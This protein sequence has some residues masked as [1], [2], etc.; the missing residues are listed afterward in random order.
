MSL[1]R[2]HTSNNVN[3]YSFLHTTYDIILWYKNSI[4]KGVAWNHDIHRWLRFCLFFSSLINEPH[5]VVKHCRS[6]FNLNCQVEGNKKALWDVIGTLGREERRSWSLGFG[7]YKRSS[8]SA[9]FFQDFFFTFL[10]IRHT[11]FF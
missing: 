1:I 9:T 10:D 2:T 5:R 7:F 11:F 3:P 8:L 6:F 4:Q